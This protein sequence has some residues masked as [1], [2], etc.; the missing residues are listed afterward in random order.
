M[1][2]NGLHTLQ[3]WLLIA[4]VA[5]AASA[6]RS[7]RHAGKPDDLMDI[8]RSRSALYGQESMLGP[9]V[10]AAAA[11]PRFLNA[12]TSSFAVNGTGIPDVTFD[13]GES[14]AGSLPLSSDPNDANKLFF[15]FFPSTNP[16]AS[17][18]IVIWLN[19]GPGCSSLEGLIQE[20][21]PFIWQYGTFR[22][23]PNT[24][25][26]NKLSNIVY[27]EQPVGTGFSVGEVTAANEED[28]ASQFLGFWKNFVDTFSLQGYKIYVTG[29]SYAKSRGMYCPYI[30]SAMLDAK[31]KTYYNA[32]G[33]LI[34]DPV[35]GYD[36][37]QTSVPATAF[38]DYWSGL[39]SFNDSFLADLH[40][41]DESCGYSDYL[42]KYLVY[43]PAGEQPTNFTWRHNTD[44]DCRRLY[45]DIIFASL[46]VN[47]CWDIYHV[48]TTCPVLWD[49]LGSPGTDDYS[50]PGAT[51][52]FQRDD[53]KK[54]IHAPQNVT[55]E[56][57]A[58]IN[59][60]VHRDRS[61]PS[62]LSVLPQV[63]DATQNVIIGH[64]AL[65]FVLVANGTLLTIQ[66]MTWGGK[67][68]FQAPP[69]EPMYV[70]FHDDFV[71]GSAAGSGV[72][73]TVHTE[74]G[75]T[76]VG[77]ALSG[78]M[79]PQ[80]AP[81]V[82]YRHL[83][84]LLGRIPSLASQAPFTTDA[85]VTQPDG[86]LGDGNAPQGFAVNKNNVTVGNSSTNSTSKSEAAPRQGLLSSTAV[87]SMLIPLGLV[88]YSIL[89]G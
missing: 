43:P 21:G 11:A 65:D 34:Y 7:L 79:I 86:A 31:D 54:A 66:N 10:Q 19:G 49:V 85:N 78:H 33:V 41:R 23:V 68:G 46:V 53:V 30:A 76:Y 87:G 14:Y 40:A 81:S 47:P 16:D 25:S 32:S 55:W 26:W 38:V 17:Q 27:I 58:N 82:A 89:D 73:G 72:M 61:L 12:N 22:P 50:P 71:T 83:E 36:D 80:Y 75:L 3:Q 51:I 59:V 20:N 9:Q 28:V 63:I 29:E 57:C 74:R 70:P 64:G 8:F 88:V 77:V 62:G 48:A 6:T 67:R 18:E 60:F 39:F 37:I 42:N 24:W 69:T 1:L 4:S 35:V 45:S 13:V 44:S 84:L 5:G 15:W 56:D 2:R 52:Y